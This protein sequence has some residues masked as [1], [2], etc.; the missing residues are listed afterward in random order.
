MDVYP[1]LKLL[2]LVT[3]NR[4]LLVDLLDYKP[5]ENI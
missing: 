1:P 4:L 2:Y 5:S 3:K